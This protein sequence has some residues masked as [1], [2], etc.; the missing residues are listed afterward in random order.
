MSEKLFFNNIRE[1][2]AVLREWWEDWQDA[3]DAKQSLQDP[4][5]SI[6][7]E[8]FK[9]KTTEMCGHPEMFIP[10]PLPAP[11]QWLCQC[12]QNKACSVCGWGQGAAPC[13]CSLERRPE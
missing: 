3:R 13:K 6:P 12:G 7:W 8:V 5:P 2:W 9:R 1:T 4:G 11:V 10:K